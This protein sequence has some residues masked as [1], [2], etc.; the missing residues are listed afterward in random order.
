MDHG[1]TW[2]R[3]HAVQRA[4]AVTKPAR[5]AFERRR[6]QRIVATGDAAAITLAFALVMSAH[7][8]LRRDPRR[9]GRSTRSSPAPSAS[10]RCARRACGTPTELAVRS[11]EL[12]SIA[13]ASASI[14]GGVLIIDR[15]LGPALRLRWIAAAAVLAFVFL[16]AVALAATARGWPSTAARAAWSARR[17]SSAPTSGRSSWSARRDPPR[18]RDPRRR[19]RR[20]VRRGRGRRPR[21]TCGS[22]SSPTLAAAV[23][24]DDA[25]PHRRQLQRH[26]RRRPRRADPGRARRWRRGRRPRRPA[27]LRRHPRHGLGD[28]QRGRSCTSSRRR[29]RSLARAA[30][31]TFDIV[32]A[33]AL[34]LVAAPVMA[35]VAIL[36]KKEDRGPVFFRQQRVGLGDARV[37]DAQVPHDVRRRRGPPR[38]RCRPTTSAPARC[39]SSPVTPGSRGSATSCAARAS[40]SCRSC[41]TS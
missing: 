4:R 9:R 2:T 1:R 10:S 38:R 23:E 27:R 25:R 28:G 21:A 15:F 18:G 13:R 31:R 7:R 11:A 14:L 3:V 26:R 24:A 22:A 12:A 20:H 30:K 6:Q 16:V 8:R 41:S 19:H 5:A 17:S 29:R 39:S 32:V 37:R 34:L 33:G 35:V 36:V 40:T